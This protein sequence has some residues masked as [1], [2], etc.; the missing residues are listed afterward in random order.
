[1][2]KTH[3]GVGRGNLDASAPLPSLVVPSPKR[4]KISTKIG[5]FFLQNRSLS[6]DRDRSTVKSQIKMYRFT[7]S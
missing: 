2:L 4:A 1:M 7:E 5:H 3:E 6:L